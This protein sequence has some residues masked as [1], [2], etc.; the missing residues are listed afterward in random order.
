VPFSR[1]A[2]SVAYARAKMMSDSL[3]FGT[4]RNVYQ[5]GYEWI[6]HSIWP[7]HVSQENSRVVIGGKDCKQKYSA[8]LLNVSGMS[9]GTLSKNA[10]L[11]LN[12]AAKM[13]NFYQNTGEGSISKF[14]LEN[15]GDIV[16]NIGTGYFGCRDA[17]EIS[18]MLNLKRLLLCLKLK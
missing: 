17:K 16:W 6:N 10:V 12:A 1:E 14:H 2:R 7:K 11:A 13:G 3:P 4:R 8:C 5:N 9:F 15:E 18:Q